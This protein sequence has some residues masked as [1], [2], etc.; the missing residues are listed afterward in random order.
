[1]LTRTPAIVLS[2]VKYGEADL[3]ARLYTRELGTQ[4]YMLKGVRK[5]RKGKLRIAFFQPLTQL[6]IVTQH[7]GKGSLEYIK[8]A[9]VAPAYDTIH[10]DIIKSSIVMFFSEILTQL[11]T[12][13]QPDEYLYDYVSSIFQFLDQTDTVANFSIKTLLDLTSHM[14]FQPDMET[15]DLPYFNLLDGSF[16]N[17]SVL[18]HHATIEESILIKQFLGT[19]FAAINEIKMNREERNSLLNL[20]IDYFQIHLHVFKKPTS[21]TILKQ[22]FDT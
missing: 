12:E 3:I 7:K 10:T 17:N 2:T 20:V 9:H 18:P 11:L 21:L 6:D 1:M 14:G 13:Q 19:N 4:S 22:L 16:D 15:I 5:S 8:E